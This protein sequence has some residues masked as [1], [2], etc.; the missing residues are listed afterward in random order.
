MIPPIL[1]T[2][3][4]VPFFRP[5]IG[6]EEVNEVAAV[7]RSGWLTAGPV[8]KQFETAFAAAVGAEHAL[9][10]NSA[11]AALHLA[12]EALGTGPGH[13]VLVPTLTFA[14]TAGVVH[15]IGAVPILVDCEPATLN[16]D[17]QDAAAKIEQVRNGTIGA[18]IPKGLDVVGIMPVHV[19]GLVSPVDAVREFARAHGLWVVE[20]AAHALPA[21]WRP[22][23]DSPWVTC[24]QNTADVTCFS[25]YANKTMTTGEG[26]MAVTARADLADRMRTMSL[27]GLSHD[28]WNRF[29]V[30]GAWDYEILSPGFKYNMTD[31][32]A[33]LGI[34]QLQRLETLRDARA[35]IAACY[36]HALRE[37]TEIEL[38]SEPDNHV[39]AWHLFAIRLHLNRLNI[40]RNEFISELQRLGVGCSVHWRPLHLH[41]YY[42]QTF[43]W[44]PAALPHAT[45]A[46]TRLVSLP[47]FPSMTAAD[48]HHVSET[49]KDVCARFRKG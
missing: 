11:T 3:V 9:A 28:A 8:V 20:D 25:F 32:A 31:I 44:D 39:H 47:I 35:E 12:L 26:G 21:R 15:H 23:P 24:G 48:R 16:I 29:G 46:W 6:E 5:T 10:V 13:A 1:K 33:A 41:P 38:P 18:N 27:H 4:N 17:L 2:R 19:G 42:R 22:A 43:A 34:H 7:L 30:G 40:D 45:E 49:V 14:A 36:R 37:V